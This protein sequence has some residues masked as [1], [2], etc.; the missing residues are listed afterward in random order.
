VPAGYRVHPIDQDDV[1]AR[2]VELALDEPAGRAPDVAA[3]LVTSLRQPQ[4]ERA[5]EVCSA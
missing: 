2:L 1:A 4:A 5:Q 3:V